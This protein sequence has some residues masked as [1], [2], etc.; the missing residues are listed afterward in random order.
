MS[1]LLLSDGSGIMKKGWARIPVHEP[2][3][4]LRRQ[5]YKE[6]RV[7]KD[8]SPWASLSYPTVTVLRRKGEQG[9]QSKSSPLLSLAKKSPPARATSLL[10]NILSAD[11]FFFLAG[12]QTAGS[13]NFF[14]ILNDFFP[15]NNNGIT[16]KISARIPDHCL[17]PIRFNRSPSLFYIPSSQLEK[18]TRTKAHHL[19]IGAKAGIERRAAQVPV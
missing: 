10:K 4:P 15:S 11:G 18:D 16:K 9:F 13:E 3:S 5:R 2:A 12:Q 17:R 7:S 1:Q 8:S 6:E 19:T 14:G